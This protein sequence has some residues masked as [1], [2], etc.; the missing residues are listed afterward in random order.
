MIDECVRKWSLMFVDVKKVNLIK[1]NSLIE[2][3]LKKKNYNN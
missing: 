3:F 2:P 1:Y